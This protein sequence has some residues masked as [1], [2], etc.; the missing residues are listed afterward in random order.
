MIPL[1]DRGL[2]LGDGL[3]ETILANDGVLVLLDEH[4]ARMTRQR[5]QL[6][7]EKLV[8]V[9]R[10]IFIL[11]IKPVVA[12]CVDFAVEH[13]LLDQELRPLKIAVA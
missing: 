11:R 3:F 1:N 7:I 10:P 12:R 6:K 13:S 4:L 2:T 8:D 9:E 5:F